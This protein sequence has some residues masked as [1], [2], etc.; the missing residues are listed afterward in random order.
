MPQ[1][2][3][4]DGGDQRSA[5]SI[6]RVCAAAEPGPAGDRE[7]P[8][9]PD[10]SETIATVDEFL[11]AELRVPSHDQLEGSMMLPDTDRLLITA[12]CRGSDSYRSRLWKAELAAFVDRHPAHRSK[13]ALL[14]DESRA[15]VADSAVRV[16]RH[17][18]QRREPVRGQVV[19]PTHR[20]RQDPV[21]QRLALWPAPADRVR[22]LAS[23]QRDQLAE[24][25]R[26]RP[27]NGTAQDGSAVTTP[28]TSRSSP[29]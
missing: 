21:L 22:T 27:V 26:A 14:D 19:P 28:D 23:R 2:A 11:P 20:N 6:L 1:P 17:P 9:E 12:D 13:P 25:S 15:E 8:A 5:A 16:L 4:P 18:E 24:L 29:P 3:T 10:R 7:Y